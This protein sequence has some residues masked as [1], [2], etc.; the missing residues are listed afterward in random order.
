MSAY[1]RNAKRYKANVFQ[2]EGFADF[3]AK[4]IRNGIHQIAYGNGLL[5]IFIE[6]HFAD[7]TIVFF[8]GSIP[9]KKITLPVFTGINVGRTTGANIVLVSDSTLETGANLAWYAGDRNRA[10][11]K[12]LPLVLDAV[13]RSMAS[14]KHAVFYGGSGGGFAA[15]FYASCFDGAL[16]IAANPQTSIAKYLEPAVLNFT[17]RAWKSDALE[18]L[19][20]TWNLCDYYS[21]V[22]PRP[23]LYLQ[24]MGDSHVELH[25]SPFLEK[26]PER[27][28]VHVLKLFNGKGHNP[29]SRDFVEELLFKAVRVNGQW[30]LLWPS[31]QT[32]DSSTGPE[33]VVQHDE[34][35][36]SLGTEVDQ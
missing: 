24:A 21:N 4:A 31:L 25:L 6:D 27:E 12:D 28:Q 16:P 11:Q 20:I 13:F 1:P 5:E 35:L 3:G 29:P 14:H 8:H 17:R 7:T 23:I 22:S 30:D 33:L 10:L 18:G 19:P 34:Y 2:H 36:E 15:L 26:I 32:D 9:A